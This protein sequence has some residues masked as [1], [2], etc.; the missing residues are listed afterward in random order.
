MYSVCER[1][2]ERERVCVCVC[3]RAP[4]VGDGHT[5]QST[6]HAYAQASM[7][8]SMHTRTE[9]HLDAVDEGDVCD[10]A[11][12]LRVLERVERFFE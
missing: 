3:L 12:A 8:A 11:S 2:K 7:H 1:E 9:P 4:Q 5:N 10:A 6:I